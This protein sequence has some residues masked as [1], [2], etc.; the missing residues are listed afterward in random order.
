MDTVDDE[1][2][3]SEEQAEQ[4]RE[5]YVDF[6]SLKDKVK[7]FV[8]ERDWEKYHNP[9]DIAISIAVEAGE[10]LEIFQWMQ[11]DEIAKVKDNG[12]VMDKIRGELADVINHCISLANNLDLDIPTLAVDKLKK[13][14]KKYPREKFMGVWQKPE[15]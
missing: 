7:K 1:T 9:K 5:Q 15:G 8:R 14:E 13:A 11:P 4:E 6:D 2:I 10:L 3:G 12:Q